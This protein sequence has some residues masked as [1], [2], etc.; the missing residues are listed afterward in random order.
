MPGLLSFRTPREFVLIFRTLSPVLANSDLVV[1]VIVVP[2]REQL[3]DV[4]SFPANGI[5]RQASV[6][7]IANPDGSSTTT[8]DPAGSLVEG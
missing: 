5:S 1:K 3:C 8:L 6:P 4:Y 7:S 2:D